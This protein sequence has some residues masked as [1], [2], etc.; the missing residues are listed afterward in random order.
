MTST[1]FTT[2]TL[3]GTSQPAQL[4]AFP[5]PVAGMLLDTEA[6]RQSQLDRSII[7]IEAL[8]NAAA[9]RRQADAE[10]IVELERALAN[11][12]AQQRAT[13]LA[14]DERLKALVDLINPLTQAIS[15]LRQEIT[16][17]R[18]RENTVEESMLAFREV[19]N[20]HAHTLAGPLNTTTPGRRNT[21]NQ[22]IIPQTFPKPNFNNGNIA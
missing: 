9:A 4:T 5:L 16:I 12:E 10:R 14:Y 7:Q 13:V 17:L 20:N 1:S 22:P 11:A 18:A 8:N 21:M 2:H 19:F 15:V 3:S 6:Q